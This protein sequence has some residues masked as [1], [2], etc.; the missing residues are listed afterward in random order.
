MLHGKVA[1]AEAVVVLFYS[2]TKS[3]REAPI[4]VSIICEAWYGPVNREIIQL[5]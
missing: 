5:F 4:D 2:K 1:S 3:F